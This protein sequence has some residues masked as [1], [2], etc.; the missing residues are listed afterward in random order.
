MKCTMQHSKDRR[1]ESMKRTDSKGEEWGKDEDNEKYKWHEEPHPRYLGGRSSLYWICVHANNRKS[2][3]RGALHRLS[4]AVLSPSH[5]ADSDSL[6]PSMLLPFIVGAI[7]HSLKEELSSSL[8]WTGLQFCGGCCLQSIDSMMK[9][10]G[11]ACLT[12]HSPFL[13]ETVSERYPF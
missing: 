1:L 8:S 6:S 12:C 13:S 5:Q 9:S 7:T 3:N 11:A 10:V 4:V 2:P